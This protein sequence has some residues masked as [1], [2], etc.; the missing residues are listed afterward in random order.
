[1]NGYYKEKLHVNHFWEFNKTFLRTGITYNYTAHT[2]ILPAEV[3]FLSNLSEA[4]NVTITKIDE[5]WTYNG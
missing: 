4:Y 1:M 5:I 3:N 2:Y